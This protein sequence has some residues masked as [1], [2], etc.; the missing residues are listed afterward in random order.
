LHALFAACCRQAWEL[1]DAEKAEKLIRISRAGWNTTSGRVGEHS[2]GLDEILTVTRLGLPKDFAARS[3]APTIVENVMRH[4][5]CV[6]RNVNDG[7][8]PRWPRWTAAAMQEAAKGF[9]RLKA[10]KQ[11]PALRTALQAHQMKSSTHGVLARQAKRRVTSK[12]RQRAASPMFNKE[13][14][15]SSN[16]SRFDRS[17]TLAWATSPS[18][19]LAVASARHGRELCS[20]SA[21]P[22]RSTSRFPFALAY[23]KNAITDEELEIIQIIFMKPGNIHAGLTSTAQSL[24]N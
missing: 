10:H 13:R 19:V 4:R 14:D 2:G 20:S 1:D 7:D 3:H 23:N 9:R 8:R 6:C 16:R 15:I 18:P 24:D 22:V 5:A 12:P 17:L 11:L 21:K